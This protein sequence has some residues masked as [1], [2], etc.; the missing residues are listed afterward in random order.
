MIDL[1]NAI[2]IDPFICQIV[3]VKVHHQHQMVRQVYRYVRSTPSG[4]LLP[5]GDTV[6]HA[7]PAALAG[8]QCYF[9]MPDLLGPDAV[10]GCGIITG[11][12]G[13]CASTL[14]QIDLAVLW[15][16]GPEWSP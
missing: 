6:W 13:D 3:Y 1:F 15:L 7:D 14:D 16:A 10:A 4:V 2:L 12:E 9:A 8:G 5:N 11:G